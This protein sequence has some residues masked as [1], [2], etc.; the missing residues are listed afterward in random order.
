MPVGRVWWSN[1]K[2]YSKDK[3]DHCFLVPL[4]AGCLLSQQSV[5]YSQYEPGHDLVK[6]HWSNPTRCDFLA[7]TVVRKPRSISVGWKSTQT[8]AWWEIHTDPRVDLGWLSINYVVRSWR[9]LFEPWYLEVLTG[10]WLFS[11]GRSCDHSSSQLGVIGVK[12]FISC[13]R[14]WIR[15]IMHTSILRCKIHGPTWDMGMSSAKAADCCALTSLQAAL[16]LRMLETFTVLNPPSSNGP[17][18][19]KEKWKT[20]QKL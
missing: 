3:P 4:V 19:E 9:S 16:F 14:S 15:K 18:L 20:I 1:N 12:R 6:L 10:H 11:L 13:V 2:K 17:T 5:W 8:L 7:F